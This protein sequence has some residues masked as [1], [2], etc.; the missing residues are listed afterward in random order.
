[1]GN[2]RLDTYYRYRERSI[3]FGKTR[4]T[5]EVVGVDLNRR[6]ELA[7]YNI[8]IRDGGSQIYS[9]RNQC[10]LSVNF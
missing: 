2:Q 4:E 9:V 6:I 1:M 8:K 7:E 10:R 5:L 3:Q